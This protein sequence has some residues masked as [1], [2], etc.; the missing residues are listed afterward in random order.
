VDGIGGMAAFRHKFEAGLQARGIAVTHSPE[1]PADAILVIA[2]TKN[3]LP[4][5]MARRRGVRIVQRL[6][7]INWIHRQRSTGARHFLRA[8]YGNLVLS[9]IRSGI[10]T[11][12]LYQSEFTHRWWDDWYGEKPV[13][14][15]VVHNGVSLSEYRPQGS[16]PPLGERCRL[17]VVEGSLGGGYDLGLENAIRLAESLSGRYG[18]PMEL[19]VVGKISAQHRAAVQARSRVP[20]VWTGPVPHARI[21][22]LDRS[23]HLFFSADVNPACPNAVIEALACGLPVVAF[24]TGALKEIVPEDAGRLVPYGGNPWRLEKPDIAALAQA[25]AEV[26]RDRPR[27]SA[28]ARAHAEAFLGLDKMMDGYLKALLEE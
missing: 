9:L 19:T 8:E 26:L 23:A 6:D 15:S 2:G 24:D 25:A 21:P 5:W 27:F 14:F 1:R 4:L 20:I 11:H 18:F 7:G 13:P 17:L 3:L 16:G 12:V 10:A 22:E 28:A